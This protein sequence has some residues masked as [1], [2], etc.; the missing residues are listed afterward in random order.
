MDTPL[1]S[2]IA[3]GGGEWVKIQKPIAP[4]PSIQKLHQH[5][6]FGVQLLCIL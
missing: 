5:S 1:T 4:D 2:G 6:Q 3:R